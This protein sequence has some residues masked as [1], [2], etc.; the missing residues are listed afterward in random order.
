MPVSLNQIEAGEAM[1]IFRND[2]N[3]Y[4]DPNI[5]FG[6]ADKINLLKKIGYSNDC[7]SITGEKCL[8]VG[9]VAHMAFGEEKIEI[10]SKYRCD[11]RKESLKVFIE[12]LEKT[13]AINVPVRHIF[14]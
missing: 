11:I 9:S 13:Y 10:N 14:M 8:N 1:P 3:L 6:K 12:K 7:R 2:A 5:P 4:F